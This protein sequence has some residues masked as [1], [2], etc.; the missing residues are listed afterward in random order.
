V[1]LGL[2]RHANTHDP[3]KGSDPILALRNGWRFDV[4][5]EG[6]Y[7]YVITN[8]SI[9]IDFGILGMVLGDRTGDGT[10]VFSQDG[11]AGD[12]S[13]VLLT[14]DS[15]TVAI[16]GG[17]SLILDRAAGTFTFYD[18]GS[19]PMLQMTDGSPDLHI[20]TGGNVVADL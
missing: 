18:S 19:Q 9:D 8:D 2:R 20:P 3:D 15:I 7:G 11:D 5:N 4:D 14:P 17:V 10:F 6:G 12:I 1:K 13:S 16:S